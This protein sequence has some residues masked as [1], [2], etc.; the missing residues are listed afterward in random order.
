MVIKQST[1][2]LKLYQNHGLHL[3]GG[4]WHDKAPQTT[5]L[6]FHMLEDPNIYHA[7]PET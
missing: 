3:M 1:F 5:S 4:K 6:S 2:V 7:W